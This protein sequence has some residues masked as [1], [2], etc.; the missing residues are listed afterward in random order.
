MASRLHIYMMGLSM[1]QTNSFRRFAP[2]HFDR[3]CMIAVRL[4]GWGVTNTT[5][6]AGRFVTTRFVQTNL[7]KVYRFSLPFGPTGVAT[8]T[9]SIILSDNQSYTVFEFC[10]DTGMRTF[11]VYS[12]DTDLPQEQLNSIKLH[13]KAIGYK[14]RHFVDVI[15][16]VQCYASDVVGELCPAGDSADVPI[17]NPRTFNPIYSI[18]YP[19]R[20]LPVA[21]LFWKKK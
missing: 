5:G 16:M 17:P 3:A 7:P 20:V 13:L 12:R 21:P 18:F 14:E 15:P 2:H 10:F 1:F 19:G 11:V 4:N 6:F 8:G 9:A